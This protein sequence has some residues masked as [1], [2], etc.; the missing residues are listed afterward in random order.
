H[1]GRS[2]PACAFGDGRQPIV[3]REKERGGRSRQTG[4]PGRPPIRFAEV[5][6]AP[7]WQPPEAGLRCI[8]EQ[9]RESAGA[10][11]GDP[12]WRPFREVCIAM[13]EAEPAVSA[14]RELLSWGHFVAR[15]RLLRRGGF[16]FWTSQAEPGP[17]LQAPRR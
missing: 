13:V 5:R 3:Y 7:V 12:D 15:P 14:F 16:G 1:D 9:F 10:G 11:A 4:R 17:I 2:L 8:P 6:R